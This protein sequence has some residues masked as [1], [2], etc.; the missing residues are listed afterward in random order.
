MEQRTPA[1]EWPG[2]EGEV[3]LEAALEQAQYLARRSQ[4]IQQGIDATDTIG[5]AADGRIRVT[6]R[7][8][9][10]VTRVVI[11]P[12]AVQRYGAAELGDLVVA[13]ITDGMR[14]AV[15]HAREA[16]A[17]VVPDGSLFDGLLAKLPERPAPTP[18][19]WGSA[20]EQQRTGSDF[21]SW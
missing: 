20:A 8:T 19:S 3:D 6:V 12:D 11:D 13:A 7:G 2:S 21:D 18:G 14:K 4:E 1:S 9:G 15:L 5:Q 17:E 16:F 10:I